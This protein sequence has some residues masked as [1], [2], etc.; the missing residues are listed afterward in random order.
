MAKRRGCGGKAGGAKRRYADGGMVGLEAA[1]RL[2]SA[3]ESFAHDQRWRQ[4]H[5]LTGT[6][7]ERVDAEQAGLAA[8]AQLAG[9]Q[10]PGAAGQ[11]AGQPAGQ[12]APSAPEAPDWAR[13]AQPQNALLQPAPRADAG[14]AG[15]DVLSDRLY[16]DPLTQ[17][18]NVQGLAGGGLVDPRLGPPGRDTIPAVVGGRGM[19]ALDGGEYVLPRDTTRK[20][21]K[22]TLD[23]LVDQ[24]HTPVQPQRLEMPGLADGGWL[25]GWF[26]GVPRDRAA[27][28]DEPVNQ[29]VAPPP[30]QVAA[31]PE[32]EPPGQ[33]LADVMREIRAKNPPTARYADGG[34]VSYGPWAPVDDI[35]KTLQERRQRAVFGRDPRAGDRQISDLEM[36]N[37]PAP[38]TRSGAHGGN[39]NLPEGAPLA[40]AAGGEKP[41]APAPRKPV[42]PLF[43]PAQ[44]RAE[45]AAYAK[46]HGGP[47]NPY[48]QSYE[49]LGELAGAAWNQVKRPFQ[50][51]AAAHRRTAALSGSPEQ[52]RSA[53]RGEPEYPAMRP[54]GPRRSLAA[55]VAAGRDLQLG[56]AQARELSEPGAA[57]TRVRPAAVDPRLAGGGGG[58]AVGPEQMPIGGGLDYVAP[59]LDYVAPVAGV[60]GAFKNV[61]APDGQAEYGKAIYS[62]SPLGATR[63]GLDA[64]LR[65]SGPAAGN[66]FG[67]LPATAAEGRLALAKRWYGMKPEERGRMPMWL[68]GDLGMIPP[69]PLEQ[70]IGAALGERERQRSFDAWD[71]QAQRQ[72]DAALKAI[73]I[74]G[75][76]DKGAREAAAQWDTELGKAVEGLGAKPADALGGQAGQAAPGL[77]PYGQAFLRREGAK[78]RR[79]IPDLGVNSVIGGL[80]E[81]AAMIPSEE[82]ALAQV[83]TRL[84]LDEPTDK[85]REAANELR[86][87][88]EQAALAEA[89]RRFFGTGGKPQG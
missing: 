1:R 77:S 48:A 23:K 46:Q 7:R 45:Q 89:E 43:N 17:A 30:Q 50:A 35:E 6:Q 60:P 16:Q 25:G 37:R 69:S 9:Y 73:E 75:D 14:G 44:A 86:R 72:H 24:T 52:L 71:K 70:R 19:V 47:P 13:R 62:D 84:G 55:D 54:G 81:A 18:V 65:K 8:M 68:A 27:Q 36:A 51:I 40:A 58:A 20:V 26:K 78:L 39:A 66:P 80:Y 82:Q 88:A 33:S 41:A 56:E 11:Q 53:L 85:A 38:N 79:L 4:G 5:Q 15:L 87:A 63:S 3:L 49:D 61:V 64:D 57:L 2:P 76:W 34:R 32:P 83:M 10:G 74:E 31:A 28:I 12:A 59:V 21:G 42:L 22:P 67:T 29:A